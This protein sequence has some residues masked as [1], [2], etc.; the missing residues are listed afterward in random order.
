MLPKPEKKTRKIKSE[1]LDLVEEINEKDRIKKKQLYLFVSLALTIGL[2]LIFYTYRHFQLPHL[3]TIPQIATTNSFSL[4]VGNNWGIYVKFQDYTY[5]QNYS[6]EIKEGLKYLDNIDAT[7]DSS[8]YQKIPRGVTIRQFE[9]N[10]KSGF[11]GLYRLS[12]PNRDIYILIN[13]AGDN[14]DQSIKNIPNVVEKIY[15]HLIEK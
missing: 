15:W 6:K 7:I 1:Q 8:L 13:I 3:P 14:L 5:N 2:S 11:I 9:E 12:V 10:N 4:D